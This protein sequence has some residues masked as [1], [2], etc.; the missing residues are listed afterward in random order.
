MPTPKIAVIDDYQNIAFECADWEPVRSQ[1]QVTV[2]NKPWA[3]E[4]DLVDKL[5]EFNI[6][7]LLRERTAFPARVLERLPNLKLIAMTGARTSS[8]DLEACAKLGILVSYTSSHPS[9]PTA[10]LAIAL[11]LSCARALPQAMQNI[12]NGRWQEDLPLG[13]ALEGKC[14]GIVGLGKLGS[15]VARIAQAIGMET[16]A[17]SQN[18][19]TEKASEHGVRRVEKSELFALADVVSVHLTLSDRTRGV[20]GREELSQMKQGAI[21][22]NTSRGPLVDEAALLEALESKRIIAGLDVY[23]V[24]PLQVNHPFRSLPNVVATPHL[25]YVVD[26]AL[27]HLYQENVANVLAYLAGTPQRLKN[28]A[29]AS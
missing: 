20:I 3:S 27:R 22:V 11:M 17:W 28:P 23:D 5:R 24:E 15:R 6:I 25:G 19:T 16:V 18:L 2:F 1:A 8:L 9:T 13:F 26:E 29:V 10:E 4:D 7:M 14:L 21:L 12:K